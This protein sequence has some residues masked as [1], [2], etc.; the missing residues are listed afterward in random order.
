[1]TEIIDEIIA[2]LL[3]RIEIYYP[4]KPFQRII[5]KIKIPKL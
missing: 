2:E 1:M 4:K 3:V 5:G